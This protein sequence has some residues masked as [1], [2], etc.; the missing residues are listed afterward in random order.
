MLFEQIKK[1]RINHFK[2]RNTDAKSRVGYSILGVL[3]GD[4]T[5]E[6]K[7]PNDEKIIS[8][9]KKFIEN[10][11]ICKDN[12]KDDLTRFT[13]EKEIEILSDYLPKQ[14]T[15]DEIRNI[16]IVTF[17]DAGSRNLGDI[18]K[19]FKNNFSG[20]YDGGLVSSIAKQVI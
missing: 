10:A 16:I 2:Q 5:K 18:M 9:I 7:E 4:S 15:E 1:D 3:I 12:A 19:H 13:S 20:Q 6:T 11:K 17:I 14:L 8:L